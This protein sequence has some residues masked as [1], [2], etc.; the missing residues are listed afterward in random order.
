MKT[1]RIVLFS[2]LA[3]TVLA[4][5][6]LYLVSSVGKGPA[7][8]FTLAPTRAATATQLDSDAAAVVRR[9]QSDGYPQTQASVLG[10][11]VHV[12]VYGQRTQVEK[13]L[14]DAL[15]PGVFY[16]RP[17][18]C[19]GPPYKVATSATSPPPSPSC[20]SSY[21]L[22]AK[23]L[24]VDTK[25]RKPT[26]AIVADPGLANVAS[27]RASNDTSSKTVLLATTPVSGL[28]QYRV[29]AGPAGLTGEDISS[30]T[31][32]RSGALWNMDVSFDSDGSTRLDDL[33]EKQ[34]HAYVAVDIDAKVVSA[35]LIEPAST[36]FTSFGGTVSFKMDL[37]SRAQAVSLADALTSPLAVPLKVA[38]RA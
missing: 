4:G 35:L 19:V 1:T 8:S 34:F 33:A 18:E 28:S 30:V 16:L 27:T 32:S 12:T 29:V 9:L 23:S 25:T 14:D 38:S 3:A 36:Y 17:L 11:L 20:D 24:A 15:T 37:D 26:G 22:S 13:A 10:R 31:V 21:L 2:L 6:A 7:N 5:V